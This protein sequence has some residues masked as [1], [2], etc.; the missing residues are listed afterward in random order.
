MLQGSMMQNRPPSSPESLPPL[1]T[2]LRE[3]DP[4]ELSYFIFQELT[5]SGI[6]F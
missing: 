1:L 5:N 2:D 6:L 3:E 4:V